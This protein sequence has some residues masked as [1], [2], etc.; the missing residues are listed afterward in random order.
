VTHD[1]Q[2]RKAK[3]SETE[4]KRGTLKALLIIYVISRLLIRFLFITMKGVFVILG[5]S[6]SAVFLLLVLFY[7][8]RN[9]QKAQ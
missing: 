3:S 2:C 1:E 4:R 5:V 7:Y 8:K 9:R 6:W